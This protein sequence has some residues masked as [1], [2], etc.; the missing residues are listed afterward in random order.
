MSQFNLDGFVEQLKE[1]SRGDNPGQV[2]RNLMDQAFADPSAV[3]NAVPDFEDDDVILFED[4]QVSIW[5]CHFPPGLHVPQH[6][7]QTPAIIG[8]YEGVERNAFYE[9]EADALVLKGSK[10]LRPGDVLAIGPQ[11]IH[12]VQAVG[13]RGSRGIHVYLS[14]LT[15]IDR[16][17]FDWN[18]GEAMPFTDANYDKMKREG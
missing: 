3:K 8:V 15:T 5:Y 1:A 4:D 13:D 14:A 6:D 10:D 12:S 9:P 2:V 7:H 16:S 18:S 17:L 11:G